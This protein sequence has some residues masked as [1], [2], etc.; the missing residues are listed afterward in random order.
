MERSSFF[1]A[2]LN[3]SGTPDRSY[4]AEDFARY[5]STFIGNGVFPNPS[6]Q[7]QV[8]AIDNNMQITIKSG[9][10]WINGYMYQNVGDYKLT[11]NNANGIL[12][13]VDR[14]VLRLDFINREIKA[15]IK[16]G[17][18]ASSPVAKTLQR[19]ADMYEIALADIYIRSGVINITQSNITDLRLNK[20]LCG[21]VH[22]TVD[23]VDTTAIFNQFQSWYSTTKSNYEKDMS[24]WTDEKKQ[25]FDT[26][27]TANTQ[28]FVS[29]FNT[30]FNTNT[31]KWDNEFTTWFSTIKGQLEGDIA[32]NL[33]SKITELEGKINA[34]PKVFEGTS[35]PIGI[36]KGD[37][38]LKEV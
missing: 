31:S 25:E 5:F 27:Y 38:W 9:Y 3:S 26:W 13:R 16:Q 15:H 4:L 17:E 29:Q 28:A 22:G 35:E 21:I 30:W 33:T 19:D 14:V 12:N 7:C 6:T 23:Q 11:L 18:F 2:I 32:A 34:I 24:V 10:A 1:N 37:F 36:S 8:V 20:E